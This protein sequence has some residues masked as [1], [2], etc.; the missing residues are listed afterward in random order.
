MNNRHDQAIDQLIEEIDRK[1]MVQIG[2]DQDQERWAKAC[3]EACEGLTVDALKAGV[4]KTAVLNMFENSNH[5]RSDA[6][7]KPM[8]KED[9][10]FHGVKVWEVTT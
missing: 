6:G 3:L 4:V 5:L 10:T 8:K 2:L 9:A 7:K 1:Q